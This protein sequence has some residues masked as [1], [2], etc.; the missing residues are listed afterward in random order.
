VLF[1]LT[2]APDRGETILVRPHEGSY[3]DFIS[4]SVFLYSYILLMS[5]YTVSDGMNYTVAD[6]AN[7][8]P[9]V[10]PPSPLTPLAGLDQLLAPLN[11]FMQRLTTID[12]RQPGQS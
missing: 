11:A 8:L 9:H 10:P 1:F 3:S 7:F 2:T 12:E 6:G 5:V 4:F